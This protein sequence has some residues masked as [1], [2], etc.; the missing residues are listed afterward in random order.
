MMR[1]K[2]NFFEKIVFALSVE[3]P[4]QQ[5]PFTWFH[6]LMLGLVIGGTVLACILLRNCSE[7]VFRRTLLTVWIVLILFEVYKQIVAPF[8]ESGGEAIWDYNYNDIPY[9]FCS[10]IH[11]VLLP[12]VFLKDGKLRDAFMAFTITFVFLAGAVVMVYP[13]QLK[14]D[15]AIGICIQTLVHHGAQVFGGA[16]IAVRRRGKFNVKFFASGAIVFVGF[17]AVAL[18]LDLILSPEVVTDGVINFFYISPYHNCPLPILGDIRNAVPWGV[19]FMIYLV[20]FVAAASL[21]ALIF[22]LA[23]RRMKPVPE[24]RD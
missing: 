21:I 9:Q 7:K 10:S 23:T 14:A 5:A 1:E 17:L 6:F 19:F 4:T 13:D 3:M 18:G 11:Y 8:S 16:L 12:I 20:G 24:D 22:R 2:M 15:R